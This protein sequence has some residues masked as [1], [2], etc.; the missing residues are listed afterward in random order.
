M[1]KGREYS[2]HNV[3]Y[4]VVKDAYGKTIWQ[5]TMSLV[6]CPSSDYVIYLENERSFRFG[7]NETGTYLVFIMD[8]NSN[9]IIEQKNIT[10]TS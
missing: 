5:S 9:S 2:C 6:L 3:P 10:I 8:P 4:V 7:I 1:F